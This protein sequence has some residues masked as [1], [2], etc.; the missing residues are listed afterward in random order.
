MCATWESLLAAALDTN[1][2]RTLIKA[3][4]LNF[5]IESAPNT[6]GISDRIPKFKCEISIVPRANPLRM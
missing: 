6:L 1:L 2:K 4:G 5:L 3:M